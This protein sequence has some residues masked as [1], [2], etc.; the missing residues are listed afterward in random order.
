L[1][2]YPI[3]QLLKV[4]ENFVANYNVHN[5]LLYSD[6]YGNFTAMKNWEIHENEKNYRKIVQKMQ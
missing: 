1:N 3:K 4:I 5:K 2:V 6:V